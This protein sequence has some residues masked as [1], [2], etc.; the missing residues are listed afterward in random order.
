MT[1]D[2]S[3]RA[4]MAA[5]LAPPAGMSAAGQNDRLRVGWIAMGGPGYHCVNQMQFSSADLVE[6]TWVCDTYTGNLNR[7]KDYVQTH[8]KN[9]PKTTKEYRD[10]LAD[11][12]VDVVFIMT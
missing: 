10:I 12:S 1:Q 5:L 3:R 4:F 7:G 2:L 9:T 8:W 11:P 6:V